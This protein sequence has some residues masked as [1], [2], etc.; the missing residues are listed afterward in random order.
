[1][2]ELLE[3]RDK[4]AKAYRDLVRSLEK[5]NRQATADERV[6]MDNMVVEIEAMEDQV[7]AARIEESEMLHRVDE[8]IKNMRIGDPGND[9]G[10]KEKEERAALVSFMRTG[11]IPPERR[12]MTTSTGS[13]GGYLV[14]DEFY[15]ELKEYQQDLCPI[16]ELA[17]KTMWDSDAVFPVVSAFGATTIV[18]EGSAKTGVTPTIGQVNLTGYKFM[19]M[20][21]VPTELLRKSKFNID[22]KLP[23]WWAKSNAGKMEDYFAEGVGTTEPKGL[24]AAATAGTNTASNSAIVAND[25][26]NWYYKLGAAYRKRASWIFADSTIALIR[27]IT[28]AVTTSGALNYVWMPGL[29]GQP[30]SLMGRPIYASDG[31]SAFTAGS[32]CGVFGDISEF[33]IAEFGSPELI[34][35]PF[36]VANYGQV[37]FVGIRVVDCDLPVAEAVVTCPIAS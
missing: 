33:Q 29:A 2:K 21:D 19:Y 3:K 31:F 9:E 23:K 13:T 35:D 7:R 6:K 20:V 8:A 25:V 36:T 28:N 1:M 17:T 32:A 37:R 24:A 16:Y 30:D 14:P 4:A 12:A 10:G 5:E 27:K 22:Q 11:E 26:I 15:K 18:S 34:R